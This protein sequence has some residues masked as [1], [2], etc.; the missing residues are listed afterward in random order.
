MGLAARASRVWPGLISMK[1]E[2]SCLISTVGE[3]RSSSRLVTER[4]A[5]TSLAGRALAG[6]NQARPE[7]PA[8]L[9]R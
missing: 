5:Q 3:S 8:L 7:R 9:A 4:V 2:R 6:R 1:V